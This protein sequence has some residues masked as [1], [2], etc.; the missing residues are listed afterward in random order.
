MYHPLQSSHSGTINPYPTDPHANQPLHQPCQTAPPPTIRGAPMGLY[1]H[2]RR[3]VLEESTAEH[4]IARPLHHHLFATLHHI[5][6]F[7]VCLGRQVV[8]S[9]A[10]MEVIYALPP[11]VSGA[12]WYRIVQSARYACPL[13]L[14]PQPYALWAPRWSMS[15]K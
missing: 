6:P 10:D 3:D 2:Y 9:S 7:P 13:L 1:V 4:S 12:V 8:E 15:C 11:C 14:T 5:T